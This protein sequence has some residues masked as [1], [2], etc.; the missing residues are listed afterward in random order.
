MER[1]GGNL[2]QGLSPV[3]ARELPPQ[4][5]VDL[6]KHPSRVGEARRLVLDQLARVPRAC[7]EF[8]IV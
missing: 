7:G 5:L 4:T 8:V 3:L 6:R 1:S 2:P